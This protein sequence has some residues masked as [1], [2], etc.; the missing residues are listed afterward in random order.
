MMLIKLFCNFLYKIFPT[1]DNSG[2]GL[3][4]REVE[5]GKMCF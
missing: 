5:F 3:G 4:V 2:H 1:L